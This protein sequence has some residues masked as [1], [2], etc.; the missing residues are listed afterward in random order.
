MSEQAATT[1]AVRN[2]ALAQVVLN[3]VGTTVSALSTWRTP[4][5]GL[6]M[7]QAAILIVS[8]GTAIGLRVAPDRWTP[9]VGAVVFLANMVPVGALVWMMNVALVQG[10]AIWDPYR[11][12][13]LS[14]ITVALLAPQDLRAGLASVAWLITLALIQNRVLMEDYRTA[15]PEQAVWGVVGFG[16]F[17][18]VLLFFRSR[19]RSMEAEKQRMAEEARTLRRI[20]EILMAVRDL[21]NT[22]LQALTLDCEVLLQHP[23][24]QG[25]VG[26]RM[27]RSIAK[28]RELDLTI[29]EFLRQAPSETSRESFDAG[30]ILARLLKSRR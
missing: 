30:A 7:A 18:V 4:S 23:E 2:V 24:L 29:E 8:A 10:H 3:V 22:P 15:I 26:E 16:S 25:R 9:R 11:P 20:N 19:Q 1:R 5:S 27:A 17:S 13:E 28:L 6:Q 12:Y 14:A 21:T